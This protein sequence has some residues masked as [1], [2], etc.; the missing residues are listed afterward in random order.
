MALIFYK[1]NTCGNIILKVKD[2]GTTPSCCGKLMT[3]L[4]PEST[5]GDLD[6]HVPVCSRNR[7]TVCVNV[8]KT[9]HP[10]TEM[11]HI[12]FI[13]L[14]T[15]RGIYLRYLDWDQCDNCNP[16]ACFTISEFELPI[17]VFTYCN[18]HGL[19]LEMC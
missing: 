8:G 13:A 14:E 4:T 16:K 3:E 1:C 5:D 11:H 19:Y 10:M 17:A 18:L 15:S 7:N 2:G 9:D 12:D 6:K